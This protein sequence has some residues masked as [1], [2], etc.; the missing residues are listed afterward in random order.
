M[1][2]NRRHAHSARLGTLKNPF[3]SE[4]FLFKF[5]TLAEGVQ[6]LALDLEP[7]AEAFAWIREKKDC[8]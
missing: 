6:T 8:F 2:L 4:S 1:P 5:A 7:G 3:L